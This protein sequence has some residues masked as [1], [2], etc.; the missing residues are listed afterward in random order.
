MAKKQKPVRGKSRRGLEHVDAEVGANL[1]EHRIRAGLS[2]TELGAKVGVTFQQIQKYENGSNAIATARLPAVCEA[3]NISPNDLFGSLFKTGKT[4]EPTPQL[5]SFAVKL[6]LA[7]EQLP[8][9]ARS[10]MAELVKAWT[11]EEISE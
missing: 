3:L 4:R 10:A 7:I 6:A 1:R 9:R 8:R 2:Q 5:S 11:G